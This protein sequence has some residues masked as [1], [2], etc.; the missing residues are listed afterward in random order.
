MYDLGRKFDEGL[1]IATDEQQAFRWYSLAAARGH[2]EAMNRL[3]M[4]YAQGRGVPQD[5]VAA[6][7]WY[8]QAVARG[9][10]VA[11]VEDDSRRAAR[12]RQ[13]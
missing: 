12:R 13:G 4:L 10:G 3:G 6:F 2:A 7:A 9:S 11:I 8:R 1:G 5:Y